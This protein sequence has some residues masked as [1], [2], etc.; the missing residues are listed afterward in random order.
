MKKISLLAVLAALCLWA[1]A[2]IAV[3]GNVTDER[4][5]LLI[6]ASVVIEGSE[7]GAVTNINGAYEFTNLQVGEYTFSV[8]YIGYEKVT[9]TL[10]VVSSEVLN[11]QLMP[12]TFVAEEILIASSRAN[13]NTPVAHTTLQ[14]EEISKM[15]IVGD[16]P[17]Q[18]E[19]TPSVIAS[20][21]T[22]TGTGYS[23]MRIRGTEM[24][25]INVTVNGVPLNDGESQGVYWVN[26]P[27]F[28]SSVN[29]IQIQRGV[30]T[31]SNGSAAFGASVNFQ[32][33]TIEPKPYAR[34]SSSV[35]SFNTFKENIAAGTG[36]IN[37][38]FA[39]DFRASKLNSDGYIQRGFSDHGSVYMSGTYYGGKDLLKAVVMLGQQKTGITWWG[40]P[41]YMIDSIRNFNP[42]GQYYDD[43]GNEK[44]Y[45]GQT[46]NYWQNHYQL[47]YSREINDNL[48][49]NTTLH[50][51]TGKG[52]Y[53][54]Y[55]ADD[56][57]YDYGL[58]NIELNNS[59]IVNGEHT[60]NYPD[61]I[62]YS[63]DIIRQKW[64]DNV[65]YGLTANLNYNIDNIDATFGI[66]A[67]NYD[68]DHFGKIKWMKFNTS[69]PQDYE[70]YNNNGKKTDISSF[71]KVQYSF[72]DNISVF[73]D[74]QIRDIKYNISG[75]DDDL[76]ELKQDNQWTFVNPKFGL[77][78]QLN[79]QQRAYASFS[80]ANREPARADIK[81][82]LKEGGVELPSHETLN[83]IEIGY[84][85][86]QNDFALGVNAFYMLYKKQLVN[87]G[88]LSS[89][90]YPIM[91]NVDNS[92]RRGVE[93]MGGINIAKGFD[94]NANLTISQN[95]IKDYIEYAYHY[96]DDW[97]ETYEARNLGENKISYSPELIAA[98]QFRYEPIENAGVNFV[99]KY[100]GEQ[101]FDNTS[102]EDRKLDAY[103]VNNV[104]FDYNYD[105]KKGP[106]VSLQFL[107]NN[108][109]DADYISN[110]YGG[111][112]YEQGIDQTWAYYFPQAGRNYMFKVAIMF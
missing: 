107:V 23:S 19:M 27:D 4:N 81:E 108:V 18:L 106:V 65:F 44:F 39:F 55:K 89:V 42:A 57:F 61:S 77:N 8:S 36:L 67:N 63:S 1:N 85:L 54:Q 100:V 82:A 34:L 53:E 31:S 96:D 88:E 92:F 12:K 45:D 46:D 69:V 60:Y 40:V 5:N 43:N 59:F 110:A 62:I 49:F 16:I 103:F 99:S 21:E 3:T 75:F 28:T 58:N 35:G 15:N 74:I 91:T 66:A 80:V 93:F 111:N 101:Y 37:N 20:S 104:S 7:K 14:K 2:Q 90:G 17:Y 84:Q 13:D 25:R 87:T 30:G 52:Y 50:T 83:D 105:F 72:T 68:G 64:L 86:K 47:H 33:V 98:S 10:K 109:F 38:K 73:G 41:N 26:M 11:F 56:D 112:W 29:S 24:S 79:Q 78:F 102:S 48:S 95:R 70:W 76:V 22:G 71:L 94:W 6:G 9:K 97:N 51:T 32:T